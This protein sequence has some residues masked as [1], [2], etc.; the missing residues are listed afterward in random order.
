MDVF[1][2]ASQIGESFGMVLAESLLCG[3]PVITLATPHRDNSQLEVVGHESGGLIVAS[4]LGMIEAMHCLEDPLVR[5][6]Y[7]EQ[8]A[9]EI[10]R[11]FG[12]EALMPAAVDI[13]RLVA[14]GLPAPELQRQILSRDDVVAEV[15][16]EDIK[17]LMRRC[18]GHHSRATLALMQMSTNPVLY[19]AYRLATGKQA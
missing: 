9:A 10:V 7:A 3:V 1:L 4:V 12:P 11:R 5:R 13:A 14:E 19:R 15:S 18:I 8:G 6:R 2:H 17:A 16:A